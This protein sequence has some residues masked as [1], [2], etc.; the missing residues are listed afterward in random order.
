MTTKTSMVERQGNAL[1]HVDS[2]FNPRRAS[3]SLLRAVKIPP[4]G[5][6]GNTDFADSRTAFEELPPA[7]KDELVKNDYVGAHTIAQSRKLGAPDFFKDLDPSQ[8]R[9][10]RHKLVQR[11]EPSGRMNLYVAAHCHHLEGPGMDD[12][13]SRQLLD[14]LLKHATQDQYVTSVSWENDGDMI[15]WD[16]RCVMH[17][18]TGGSF[19]GRHVR[20]LR[21]TTV[22][23]D[24]PTAWGLNLHPDG[25]RPNDWV[26]SVAHAAAGKARPSANAV[27]VH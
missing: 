15:I 6:G 27:P 22:H 4:P 19:E 20:D 16:N 3:Y 11:H 25:G 17:R 1:F 2:S 8:E 23:D 26:S 18:A 21:R 10:A 12:T 24:S 5:N 14:T 9:M 13:K 7:L